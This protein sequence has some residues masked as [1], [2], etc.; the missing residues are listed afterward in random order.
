MQAG[1]VVYK[2][3]PVVMLKQLE[4][5]STNDQRAQIIHTPHTPSYTRNAEERLLGFFEDQSAG[6][7]L[8][9]VFLTLKKIPGE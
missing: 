6:R 8:P 9:P 4:T 1:I 3:L 2:A 5:A 7:A